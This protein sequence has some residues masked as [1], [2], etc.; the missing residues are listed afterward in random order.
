[1]GFD[2]LAGLAAT[3]VW[4]AADQV[5]HAGLHFMRVCHYAYS[6]MQACWLGDGRLARSVGLSFKF[7]LTAAGSL[8]AALLLPSDGEC[9]R[10][11]LEKGSRHGALLACLMR[12]SR[13]SS[14][15]FAIRHGSGNCMGCAQDCHYY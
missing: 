5:V 13:I 6:C 8:L 3:C 12:L 11:F 2:A 15:S 7:H 10:A 4:D 9:E 1:M 14:V